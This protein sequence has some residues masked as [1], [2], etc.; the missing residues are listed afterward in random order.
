MDWGTTMWLQVRALTASLLALVAFGLASP[1]TSDAP[2]QG[3]AT[4]ATR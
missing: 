4:A 3:P 1:P 2:L